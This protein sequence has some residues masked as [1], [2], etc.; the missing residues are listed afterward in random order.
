MLS[1]DGSEC[2]LLKVKQQCDVLAARD[3]D[4]FGYKLMSVN[5]MLRYFSTAVLC[6]ETCCVHAFHKYT[7]IP[8]LEAAAAAE[9]ALPLK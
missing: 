7:D 5:Q 2:I 4:K 3:C 8:E 1:N 9:A 6:F